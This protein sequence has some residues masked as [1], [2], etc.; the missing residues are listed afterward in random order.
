MRNIDIKTL[1]KNAALLG[2]VVCY[3][4]VMVGYVSASRYNHKH[5]GGN[6]RYS[7]AVNAIMESDMFSCDKT[8]AVSI[9]KRDGDT[10]FYEAIVN[11]AKNNDMFSSDKLETIRA[12]S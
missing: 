5:A 1:G 3:G 2:K 11:I 9:L 7:G 12:L 4:L 10:E 8:E 6:A